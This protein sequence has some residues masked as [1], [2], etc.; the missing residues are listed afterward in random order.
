MQNVFPLIL[1]AVVYF[2]FVVPQRRKA[3]ARIEELSK[4]SSGDRV[5]LTS[6]V[7]G[8][9]IGEEGPSLIVQV[10]PGTPLHV[11]R[12]AV[13]RKTSADEPGVPSLDA[14]GVEE[15]DGPESAEAIDTIDLS[16]E[17]GASE[18]G[19]PRALPEGGVPA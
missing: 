11:T 19:A 16:L 12:N 1:I 4:L 5:L 15:V 6:G 18:S 8:V 7:F 14:L 17:T 2:A 3:K 10:A 9:V 13:A